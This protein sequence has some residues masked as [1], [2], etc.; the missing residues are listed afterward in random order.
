MRPRYCRSA[1]ARIRMQN[2][3]LLVRPGFEPAT[4]RSADWRPP[5]C[6]NQVAC[7]ELLTKR[8][9]VYRFFDLRLFG[10]SQE[11]CFP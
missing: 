6:A 3:L 9:S 5:N 8:Y 2:A 11:I 7:E 4:S 10:F 1:D